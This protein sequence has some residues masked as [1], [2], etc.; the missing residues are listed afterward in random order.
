[1]KLTEIQ[2]KKI[3]YLL[4]EM[5]IDEKIG[6]LNQASVSIVGGFDVPFEELI[7]MMTDGKIS[8]DEFHNIMANSE[9]Y[10][11][12]DEIK[13]G[14]VGSMM[15]QDPITSNRLQKIAVEETRLGIP[16][17]IGLDVIHGYKTVFPI[18]LAEAGSFDRNLMRR[19]ARMAARESRLDGIHWHFA[20]MLDISRD[21][22]W[23]RVS[24][25]GGEDPYLMSEFAK[26]K[27]DGLQND[28]S[29]HL[30]YVAACL[31]HYVGYGACEGGR[32]YNTVTMS[33]SM[34]R[35]VYLAP[36]RAGIDAGAVSVMA[37]FNDLNGIPCTVNHELLTEK[38]RDEFG[39]DGFVV[40]DANAIRECVTHGIVVDE[41]E[42]GINSLNA[43]LDMDMGT[44]IYLKTLKESLEIGAIDIEIINRAV[45]RIL[46]VKMWLG[47]FENPY[48]DIVEND[49]L[50]ES[51]VA[52]AL[53]SAEKSIVLLKNKN[54]LLPLAK[55]TKI[56]L[57]GEL[58]NKA[59]EVSGA[60][61]IS[62]REKDGVSLV[63]GITKEFPNCCYFDVGGLTTEINY[64]ALEDAIN[65]ADVIVIVAGEPIS[66]SGEAASRTDISL[67]GYQSQLFDEL[68]KQSKPTV[69]ILMN[70]RPL[71]IEKESKQVDALIEAWHLGIQMGNAV[72]RTL[73]GVNNPSGKLTVSFPR[74]SGQCPVYYNHPN[75]GRPA[76]KSKFTSKYL[77][78]E[79]GP[80]FQ[81]GYG[82]S[83][84]SFSFENIQLEEKNDELDVFIDIINRSDRDGEEVVQL[85]VTDKVGSI[86][87][88]VK[89]LKAFEKVSIDAHSSKTVNMCIS[90]NDFGFWNNQG[91]YCL[92]DGEFIITISDGNAKIECFEIDIKF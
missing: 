70:G 86:V 64:Q 1:M 25:G 83:Y 35:N 27:I 28:H 10:Y 26:A 58:A 43:G 42:A 48:V 87:R 78:I 56:S 2:E 34:L 15:I 79:S 20:P 11:H 88:P 33:E 62:F 46:R 55:K 41:I 4:S 18:A 54:D 7:E 39:F 19:T 21:A 5:T 75:T 82:L 40:S 9:K 68:A 8:P 74:V 91:Q 17:I 73:S 63:E 71:A 14:L 22:R 77:D 37:A 49:E 32:D 81:F 80:L 52:L 59:A 61:A 84:S 36:F 67:P 3:Q 16:L 53:E 38:L 45:E 85:Y 13:A 69:A 12:E 89:E 72:A 50:P 65:Y 6:Q 30:N 23:G 31:K 57:I 51:N 66:L 24:E 44:E 92:E 47:L 29:S 60:W 76:G 90:K